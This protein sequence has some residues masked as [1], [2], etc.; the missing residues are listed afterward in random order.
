MSEISQPTPIKPTWPVK[1]DDPK[2]KPSES[3][4]QKKKKKVKSP[5]SVIDGDD[6][7]PRIDDY[8]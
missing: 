6:K 7:H 1:R 5:T 8:A 3:E 2:R 4:Q